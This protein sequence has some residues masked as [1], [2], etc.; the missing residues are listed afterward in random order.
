[1]MRRC[2][3]VLPVLTG[4]LAVFCVRPALAGAASLLLGARVNFGA[5][6]TLRAFVGVDGELGPSRA[7]PTDVPGA[8]RLPVWTL[9]L[10]LGAT[11]GTP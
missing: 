8:P 4:I 10:A 11:V 3:A 2:P 9:G 1:M 6:S 7:E 5:L